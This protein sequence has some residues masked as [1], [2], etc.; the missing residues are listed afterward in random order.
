MEQQKPTPD[1]SHWWLC[2]LA[3]AALLPLLQ[4]CANYGRVELEHVSHPFAGP[5]F[6]PRN[7][8]D[9]LDQ[10]NA[11]LGMEGDFYLEACS[12]Y[13]IGNGG[14]FGPRLTFTARVGKR[15]DFG[16]RQ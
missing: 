1:L 2:A 16:G 15:F 6:G 14:F 10:L 8:E 4:G 3:F 11:C 5:P 13:V 9:S 7:E 12:G